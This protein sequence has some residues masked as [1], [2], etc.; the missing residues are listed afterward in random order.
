MGL[1]LY[2]PPITLCFLKGNKMTFILAIVWSIV[3][4]AFVA[5][6]L[7]CLTINFW[8]RQEEE[9]H[10]I[11]EMEEVYVKGWSSA[12]PMWG[13]VWRKKKYYKGEWEEE[14]E[15]PEEVIHYKPE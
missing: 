2:E 13:K 7:A 11:E 10:N 9:V 1:K 15:G 3:A 5:F 14:G 6:M 4:I 8:N 12:G